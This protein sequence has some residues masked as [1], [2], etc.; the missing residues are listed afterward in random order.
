MTT[1]INN[2]KILQNIRY[3]IKEKKIDDCFTLAIH[4]IFANG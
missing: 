2:D 3:K 1:N 4:V